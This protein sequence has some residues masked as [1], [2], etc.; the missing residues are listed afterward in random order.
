[1]SDGFGTVKTMPVLSGVGRST[2]LAFSIVDTSGVLTALQHECDAGMLAP[3]QCSAIFLQH[4]CSA[5]LSESP[6]T[7]QTIVGATKIRQANRAAPNLAVHL[8]PISVSTLAKLGKLHGN[9]HG[10]RQTEDPEQSE[11]AFAR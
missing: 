6:G 5:A 1:V 11:H 2:G 8:T 10:Q 3:P 7:M 4:S 9:R